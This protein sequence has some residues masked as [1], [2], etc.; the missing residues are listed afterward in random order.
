MK[1]VVVIGGGN[2]GAKS[3]RACRRLIDTIRLSGVITISD[4]GGSSG[5]LRDEFN[6]L[7]TGDMLRAIMAMSPKG[8]ENLKSIF[9]SPRFEVD[10]KLQKHNVGNLFLTLA[11]QYSGNMMDAVQALEQ[12]V[13]A[14]GHVYPVSHTPGT[15]VATMEDGTEVVGEH[16][17]D[18]PQKDHGLITKLRMDPS[19]SISEEAKKE[20]E[21]ADY[22][23]LGPGSLYCS[24][25]AAL[26]PDGVHKAI[27]DSSAT[28]VFV[29][30]NAYE[31]DGEQGPTTL[32]E[33]VAVVESYLPRPLDYVVYNNATLNDKQTAWYTEKGWNLVVGDIEHIS[34][35][36]VV[37]GDYER[38]ERPGLSSEKLSHLLKQIIV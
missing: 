6:S 11:A 10:G 36:T 32:S 35:P 23:V 20:I 31:L 8:Y 12:A 5:K 26:L 34:G 1:N 4:S 30:G 28:L 15:I 2:G 9:Y 7:P 24:V 25:V 13:D 29:P 19:I 18:R 27:A 33:I 14:V 37:Q 16:D 38:S 22:I 3:I 17:I 21:Q